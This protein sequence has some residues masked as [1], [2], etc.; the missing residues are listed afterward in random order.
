MYSW[1]KKQAAF[2]TYVLS[3][4]KDQTYIEVVPQ[5]GGIVSVYVYQGLDVFYLDEETLVDTSKNIRGGNPVL[6]PISSYLEN[7]TY[8]YEGTEYQ[9]KQHGFARNL[10]GQVVDI[11][12]DE[13]SASITIE[14]VH[15]DET[16]TR[17]PFEFKLLLTYTLNEQGLSTQA[18]VT[19]CD[20]KQM[21]FYLG[22]HPYFYVA[23]KSK[24]QLD[25]PSQHYNELTANS[26]LEGRFSLEQQES[27]AIYEQLQAS[28][29]H[30]VDQARGLK[31]S[32]GYDDVYPYI[33]LWALEGK[34]FI[35][36]EPWMAP[37][38][39][40]NVNKGIQYLQAGETH[41]S[42]ITIEAQRV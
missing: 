29:C 17:Y 24:L 14:I 6:F 39:G 1:H 36:I 25:I 15:N 28:S 40:M 30:M 22:Y 23:D 35:C 4:E 21:P 26:V 32:I 20:S 41:R 13:H 34:P 37:V 16:L 10:P 12:A 9:L 5:R 38:N 3:S 27:N 33:V 42:V 2:E 11:C 19:N 7:E 31:V 8:T 18:A